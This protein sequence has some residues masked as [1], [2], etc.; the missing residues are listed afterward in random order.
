MVSSKGSQTSNEKRLGF[1]F[2]LSVD[3]V[4]PSSYAEP[5]CDCQIPSLAPQGLRR[6]CA[7][8]CHQAEGKLEHNQFLLGHVV[9]QTTK[10]YFG[11]KQ[12]FRNAVND[13]IGLEPDPA[14][15]QQIPPRWPTYRDE[16]VFRRMTWRIYYSFGPKYTANFL[17]ADDTT[18]VGL[19]RQ[20]SAAAPKITCHHFASVRNGPSFISSVQEASTVPAVATNFATISSTQGDPV[21]CVPLLSSTV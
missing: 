13:R 19:N 7:R 3:I 4:G 21:P 5:F 16:S 14:G 8:L 11:C 10:R 20:I 1:G 9:V 17:L 18:A 6:T 15:S 12:Q 2:E